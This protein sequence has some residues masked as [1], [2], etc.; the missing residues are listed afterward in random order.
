MG[1]KERIFE[2]VEEH[3]DDLLSTLRDLVRIDTQVPPGQ[4]KP[5][6]KR[7]AK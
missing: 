1:D 2:Y 4:N 5:P 3:R 7:K 6:A